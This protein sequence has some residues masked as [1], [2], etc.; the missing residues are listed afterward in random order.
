V[1]E[2]DRGVLAGVRSG[3]PYSPLPPDIKGESASFDLPLVSV[4]GR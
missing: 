2:F 3:S 1:P 4:A